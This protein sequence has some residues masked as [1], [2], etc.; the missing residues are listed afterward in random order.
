M[1]TDA[2]WAEVDAVEG[3]LFR[4]EADLLAR[5]ATSPWCEVGAWKGR[6]TRVLAR[7]GHGWVV[8]WF[9]GSSE[10]PAGTDTRDE[11]LANTGHLN[12]TVLP[13]SYVTACN[14]IPSSLQLLY[15]DAEHSYEGTAEAFALFAP[16]VARTGTVV[17]HDAWGDDGGGKD[18]GGTPW[19]GVTRFVRELAEAGDW[20]NVENAARCA[21]FR[22]AP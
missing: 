19:P 7:G 12:I 9:K 3:W 5:L 16:L 21:V 18:G 1:L 11:F 8:D 2:E 4:E 13:Y 15:L 10:H 20:V 17:F 6:A 22:R 14:L